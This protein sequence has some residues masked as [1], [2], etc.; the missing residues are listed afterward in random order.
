MMKKYMMV[1]VALCLLFA[2]NVCFGRSFD[3]WEHEN[4]W[5][6]VKNPGQ[7]Q[8]FGSR[9]IYA[10]TQYYSVPGMIAV[11]IPV[12]FENWNDWYVDA[13]S[14]RYTT[15]K[16]RRVLEFTVWGNFCGEEKIDRQDGAL[17]SLYLVD[18]ENCV[19][20]K[21]SSGG[22]GVE[23]CYW[24]Q[25][26]PGGETGFPPRDVY[27]SDS[28]AFYGSY[29]E[30]GNFSLS[31]YYQ[32]VNAE[33]L[34]YDKFSTEWTLF[35]TLDAKFGHL[36]D[37]SNYQA[38]DDVEVEHP[39]QNNSEVIESIDKDVDIIEHVPHKVIPRLLSI[40]FQVA[41]SRGQ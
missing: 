20:Y 4:S 32:G 9:W 29:D 19:L 12:S 35:G 11:G 36:Y 22:L 41:N 16:D 8:D 7:Y 15:V 24:L 1:F 5:I 10:Y 2:T 23:W 18:T 26:S 40:A 17:A 13:A 14:V 33:N 31:K 30:Y 27:T 34:H 25:M 39:L 28:A 6:T 21:D 38:I 37:S 3:N